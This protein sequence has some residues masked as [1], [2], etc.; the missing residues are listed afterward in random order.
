MRLVPDQGI[1]WAEK[2]DGPSHFLVDTFRGDLLVR[3][4]SSCFKHEEHLK[5]A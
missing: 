1:V 2:S 3:Y 4:C 5:R